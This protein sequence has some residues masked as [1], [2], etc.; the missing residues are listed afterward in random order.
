MA[1]SLLDFSLEMTGLDL[2]PCRDPVAQ[3]GGRKWEGIKDEGRVGT[4]LLHSSLRG[5]L[6]K[7]CGWKVMRHARRRAVGLD[8]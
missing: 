8:T 6:L 5:Q 4:K 1:E 2:K 3:H 7:Q